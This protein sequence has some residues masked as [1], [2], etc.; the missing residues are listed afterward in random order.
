MSKPE[1]EQTIGGYLLRWEK[2]KIDIKVSRLRV[3]PSDGRVTGEIL[4][5]DTA[6]GNLPLYP[7][8]NLNFTSNQV[9]SRLIK[10]LT[11]EDSQRKIPL[12]WGDIINQLS[13]IVMERS[14]EGE[15]VRE[16]WTYDDMPAP[17]FFLKPL[18][19][20]GL[21]TIIFGEKAVCKSTI[22]LLVYTSL[23][24][25]W[26]DNP[27]GWEVPDRS[28]KVL[29]ADYEVDYEIAQYNIKQIQSGMGLADFPLYY[30]R[31]SLPLADDIEQLHYHMSRLNAEVLIVDSLGPAVGGDLKDPGQA[32]KFTSMLRQLRCATLIIGQTSKDKETKTKSTF[33]SVFFE[34]Y[35]RNI[36]EIKKVQEEGDASLD[37]AIYNTYHNLGKKFPAKGYHLDFDNGTQ[38]EQQ[39]ITVREL[40]ARMGTQAEILDLLKDNQAMTTMDIMEELEIK[41]GAADM[42]LKRLKEKGKIKKVGLEW[43]LSV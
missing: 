28:I 26:Q 16:L 34:Y 20:K 9:R 37:I 40:V 36:F 17:E 21:P 31:C 12:D 19:Y 39:A 14:R 43:I 25:P 23:I 11:E 22:G 7:Q 38:I 30:R 1:V 32:L 8:T 24:L 3:H 27:M 4:I 35:A 33:G 10:T 41:R 18:L 13:Y 6:N 29:Y 42:A 5:T 15:P 2:E